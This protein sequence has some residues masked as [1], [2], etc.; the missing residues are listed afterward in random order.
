MSLACLN[1]IEWDAAAGTSRDVGDLQRLLWQTLLL[2]FIIPTKSQNVPQLP[3]LGISHMA[4]EPQ[5][6][7]FIRLPFPRGD[8][9]DPPPVKWDSSKDQTLWDILSR[10]SKGREIDCLLT[11]HRSAYT[12][13]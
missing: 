13:C 1:T 5:F 8:F 10:T 9:V 7:V 4:Q 2:L 12:G 3:Q 11:H 6:T